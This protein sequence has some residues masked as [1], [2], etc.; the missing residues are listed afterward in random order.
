MGRLLRAARAQR[1]ISMFEL[2]RRTGINRSTLT[3]IEAGETTQPSTETLNAIAPQL[4]LD[5]EDLY[6]ARWRDNGKPLPSERTYFRSKYRLSDEQLA[7]LESAV[8]RIT[9]TSTEI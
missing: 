3:R 1:G 8:A 9:T 4:G 6:D 2:A 5:P 7:E